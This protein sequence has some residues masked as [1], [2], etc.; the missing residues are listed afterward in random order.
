MTVFSPVGF[1]DI[2]PRSETAQLLVT[3]Q[4]TANL[5]LIQCGRRILV[6]AIEEGRQTQ[7]EAS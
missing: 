7:G 6:N 5:L 2:S 3:G 4:I 1:G